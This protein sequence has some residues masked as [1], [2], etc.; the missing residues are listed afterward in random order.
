MEDEEPQE[1]WALFKTLDQ[2]PKDFVRPN[3]TLY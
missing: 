3:V 1:G 2:E